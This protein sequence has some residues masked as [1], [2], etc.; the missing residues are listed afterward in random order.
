[1]RAEIAR[2]QKDAETR[3][4]LTQGTV[5]PA[6]PPQTSLDSLAL[7][8][9][10]SDELR[11]YKAQLQDQESKWRTAFERAMKENEQLR[12]RG[13]EALIIAQLREQYES[14]LREKNELQEKVKIYEKVLHD[15]PSSGS[16]SLEQAY[17]ELRDEYKVK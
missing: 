7:D 13:S 14:C 15:A 9:V 10:A 12:T 6:T 17:I 3:Q 1:M 5:L 11:K 2:K 8:T 4:A 16:K